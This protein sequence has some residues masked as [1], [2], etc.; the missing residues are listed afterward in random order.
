MDTDGVGQD[1]V[2]DLRPGNYAVT[3]TLN[4]FSTAKRDGIEVTGA[5]VFA[6][7]VEMPWAPWRKRSRSAGKNAVVDTQSVRRQVVL[8]SD[9]VAEIAA[10]QFVGVATA[11]AE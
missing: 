3:F 6:I 7:N 10:I 8:S 2:V 9:V 1:R 11:D 4:G 5:G